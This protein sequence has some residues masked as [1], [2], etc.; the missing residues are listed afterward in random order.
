MPVEPSRIEEDSSDNFRDYSSSDEDEADGQDRDEE[1]HVERGGGAYVPSK[2]WITPLWP[3][4]INARRVTNT[5]LRVAMESTE[6]SCWKQAIIEEVSTLIKNMT[7]NNHTK[8][9][10]GTRALT[11][12]NILK[13][14]QNAAGSPAR[15]K[16]R[17]VVR[18][19]FQ[20]DSENYTEL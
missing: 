10:P 3:Y 7:W 2:E 1:N 20:P 9:P 17:M 12:E 4:W 8:V 16:E 6:S 15:F 5:P 19:N 13:L 14:K 11:S 18:D